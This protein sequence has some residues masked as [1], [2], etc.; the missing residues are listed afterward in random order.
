[1]EVIIRDEKVA[2]LHSS[3]RSRRGWI[4]D[5]EIPGQVREM[6]MYDKYLIELIT[7][8]TPNGQ[9]EELSPDIISQ[10]ADYMVATFGFA[11]PVS[12]AW[13]DLGKEFIVTEREN[14]EFIVHPE[15]EMAFKIDVEP[16]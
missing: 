1:M 8:N 11:I 9:F 10:V 2:V 12:V 6:R 5:D 15:Y 7:N 4:T 14:Q 16:A 3:Q 13:V